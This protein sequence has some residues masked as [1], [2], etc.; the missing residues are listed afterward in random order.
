MQ[1]TQEA[2]ESRET[3]LWIFGYG[4][5]MWD[6]GFPHAGRSIARLAGYRRGFFMWSWHYRGTRERPGLVLALDR[7][8]G[9]TCAGVAFRVRAR[10]RE[11][12]LAC[13]RARE[14]ISYAYEEATVEI[15]L[16]SGE[17]VRALTYVVNRAHEQYAGHLPPARAAEII[18]RAQGTRGANAEY[19]A[20]TAAHLR[21]LGLEDGGIFALESRVN[22]LCR[23]RGG[24]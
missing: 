13:L 15:T 14:L 11:E 24:A 5:L 17:R 6:P 12:V 7:A 4:S 10:D 23:A 1:E 16:E 22:A 2:Q 8:A 19:L 3:P 21:E 18:A 9:S 20:N